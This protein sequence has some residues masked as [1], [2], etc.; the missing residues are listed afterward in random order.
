[1]AKEN[2]T[3]YKV[4]RQNDNTWSYLCITERG[5]WNITAS[6]IEELRQKVL[7]RD[8]PW[9]DESDL[10][11][12]A[13]NGPNSDVRLEAVKKISDESVLAEVAKNAPDYYVRRAAVKKREGK[14]VLYEEEYESAL[15]E[16]LEPP[17]ET[18]DSYDDEEEYYYPYDGF[19]EEPDYG[20]YCRDD[21]S[22]DYG[23]I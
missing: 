5:R 16:A 23:N 10:A 13:K 2:V 7:A 20:M 1:M 22:W 18:R 15:F 3:D 6:S 21:D 8:L 4:E 17:I 12:V 19:S 9:H 11:D 14:S